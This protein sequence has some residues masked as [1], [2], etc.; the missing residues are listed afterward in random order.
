MFALSPDVYDCAQWRKSFGWDSDC[1]VIKLHF[2][3]DG[4]PLCSYAGC[5]SM[6]PAEYVILSMPPWH[7]YKVDNIL[8]GMLIPD[9]L[10]AAAQQNFFNKV[11]EVDLNPLYTDGFVVDGKRY[12]VQIF[13]QTLDLKGREKFLNQVS[14]QSYVGCSRCQT[15]FP[16]G[17]K[18][19]C[20]GI[21]RQFLPDGHPLR[22]RGLGRHFQYSAPELAGH[23]TPHPNRQIS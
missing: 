5:K 9:G 23:N 19:P 6:T 4:F 15:V 21:A 8:I 18:G 16:K 11:I 2:C 20:F 12:R 13:G 10:S 7:R 14:V 3:Y 22:E 1:S 17:A